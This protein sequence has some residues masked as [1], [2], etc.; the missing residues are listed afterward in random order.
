MRVTEIFHSIQG[1][2]TFAGLPC[3]FV[4]VTGCPLRCTWCDTT[5]AFYDGQEMS[6]DQIVERVEKLGCRLVE[7]TGGEP[8][9]HPDAFDLVVRLL[10]EGYTVLVET[11]G[12]IDIGPLDP[13]AVVIMDLKCPGS[14]MADRN[15]W[16][17][18][19]RLKPRDQ[20]KFVVKDREDYL[21]TREVI[22]R[23]KLHERHVVLVSP[24]LGELDPKALADWILA[25]RLPIRLQLQ[26]HKF[27]WDPAARGV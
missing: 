20:V 15:V 19:D 3:V 18:L 17:N 14:G 12:A 26:L 24:V 2:S 6:L 9:H 22:E 4:R 16:S 11:S 8:L 27:I 5:Y 25:D 21:W 1:E 10:D 7:V 13:R 23:T